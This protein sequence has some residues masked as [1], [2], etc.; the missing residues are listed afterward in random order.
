MKAMAMALVL[1]STISVSADELDFEGAVCEA[2]GSVAYS[3][4]IAIQDEDV[5]EAPSVV[6]VASVASVSVQ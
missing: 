2:I 6:E 4:E 1:F 3:E 5:F